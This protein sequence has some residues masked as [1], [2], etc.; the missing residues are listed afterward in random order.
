M[1]TKKGFGGLLKK[2]RC[3]KIIATSKNNSKILPGDCVIQMEHTD[4][5]YH[6][7]LEDLQGYQKEITP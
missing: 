1:K 5:I 3:C 2:D 6:G 7:K 4:A